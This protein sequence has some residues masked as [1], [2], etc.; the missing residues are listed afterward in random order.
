MPNDLWSYRGVILRGLLVSPLLI[1]CLVSKRFTA[2][3]GTRIE[4]FVSWDY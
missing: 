1:P 3:Y 4:C 2:K